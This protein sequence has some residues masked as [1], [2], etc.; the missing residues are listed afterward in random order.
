MGHTD[1]RLFYALKL[2]EVR[3]RSYWVRSRTTSH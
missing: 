1:K 3:F 2:Y